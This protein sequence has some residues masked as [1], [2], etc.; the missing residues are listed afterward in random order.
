LAARILDG[1]ALANRLQAEIAGRVASFTAERGAPPVLA[2]VLVGDD[3][4]SAV[5]VRNKEKACGRVGIGSRLVRL[6]GTTATA[7]LARHIAALNA[8]ADVHGILVQLPLPR[9]MDTRSILDAVDPLKDV[10]AFHPLN[11]GLLSQGRPRFLPCTPHGVLQVLADAQIS[12]AGRDV[13]IVGRSDIVGKPLAMLLAAKESPLD[14]ELANATVT[15]CHSRTRDLARVT[16]NADIVIAA[17]GQPAA[18]TAS[19]IRPGAVVVDVGINRTAAGLVGDVDFA[20]VRPIASAITPVPGGIGPLTVT[21]LLENTLS[22]ARLQ[23]S[24]NGR[25]V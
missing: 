5:Y 23:A 1:R 3:P 21:M 14:D 8:D 13:A 9:Q 12:V 24:R 16:R 4:A 10:D 17:I 6:P 7:E 11:V 19:M 20:A 2:A 22:A 15:L 18:I 25:L